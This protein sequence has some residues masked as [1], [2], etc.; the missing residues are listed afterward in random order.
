MASPVD[1]N[2]KV[3]TNHSTKTVRQITK[4]TVE[5]SRARATRSRTRLYEKLFS[6]TVDGRNFVNLRLVDEGLYWEQSHLEYTQLNWFRLQQLQF[7]EESRA[8]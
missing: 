3:S 7:S 1:S 4:A 8:V 2:M 6:D 5:A